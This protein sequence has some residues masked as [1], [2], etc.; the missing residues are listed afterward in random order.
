MATFNYLDVQATATRLIEQ[1][2]GPCTITHLAGGTSR[3]TITLVTQ[4]SSDVRIP[5]VGTV[6]GAQ[7]VGFINAVRTPVCVGDTVTG[8]GQTWRVRESTSYKGPTI[9]LAYRVVL[10]S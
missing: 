8:Y 10:D 4:E 1:F 6:S 5:V 3:G 9:T 7:V 2:G